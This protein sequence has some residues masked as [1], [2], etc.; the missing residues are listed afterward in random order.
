MPCFSRT[1]SRSLSSAARRP[2]GQGA[3]LW[4]NKG[5]RQ[6]VLREALP[7]LL[8]EQVGLETI[9]R[10]VPASYLRAIFGSYLASRFVYK[11]GISPS[12]FAFFEF[13]TPY[14]AKAAEEQ[15]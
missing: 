13:M 9:I 10:N 12:Q 3:T 6:V 15:V 1:S 5:L 4:N 11:H 7:K 14:F 8:Q 2:V